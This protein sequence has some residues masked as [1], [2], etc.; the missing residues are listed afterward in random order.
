MVWAMAKV[1]KRKKAAIGRRM[2]SYGM[3]GRADRIRILKLATSHYPPI[4]KKAAP[5][6]GPRFKRGI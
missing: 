5:F 6:L 2:K 4:S 1:A 3:F